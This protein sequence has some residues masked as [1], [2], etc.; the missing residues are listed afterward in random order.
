M[1]RWQSSAADLESENVLN[2]W[3][4]VIG[5]GVTVLVLGA[6]ISVAYFTLLERKILGYGQL[7]KGPTKVG[8]A[9]LFQPFADVI[10]LATKE[11]NQQTGT[12][13]VFFNWSPFVGLFLS[14]LI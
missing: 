12:N 7:R 3:L 8:P 14:L 10:K 5:L 9:G 4:M 11:I 6:C 13:W 2:L 1:P